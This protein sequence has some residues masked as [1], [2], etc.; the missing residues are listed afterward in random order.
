[1]ALGTEQLNSIREHSDKI[2]SLCG[3]SG[4]DGSLFDQCNTFNYVV[5]HLEDW[6]SDVPRISALKEKMNTLA[7]GI[8]E[9]AD[10][11]IILTNY[12]NELADEMEDIN[13]RNL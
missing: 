10:N 2:V 4:R 13:T 11:T 7:E 3:A 6:A 5:N 12:V 1:M 9:L 8:N